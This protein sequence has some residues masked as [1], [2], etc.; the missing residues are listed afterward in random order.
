MQHSFLIACALATSLTYGQDSAPL[1]EAEQH[2]MQSITERSVLGTVSFLSSDEMAGRDTPS[3]ELRIASAY[4]AARLRGA[5]LEGLGP[6]GS[7]Y[8]THTIQT[9]QPPR[10]PARLTAEDGTVSNLLVV[11]GSDEQ[12]EISGKVLTAKEAQAADDPV[13]AIMPEIRIPP[14]AAGNPAYL[15]A[16]AARDVRSLAETGVRVVLVE[17]SDDSALPEMAERLLDR[18]LMPRRGM[19]PACSVVLVPES[20]ELA[21]QSVKLSVD[22]QRTLDEPVHNVLGILRGSDPQLSQEA[23]IVSA[24]LDHIGVSAAGSDRINNGADDNATGV[25][26]VVSMAD[27]FAA[28]KTRPAR[29][30]I[31]CTFWGEEKGLVGSSRFV[32]KPLWPLE[33]ITANINIEMV[34]R[35]EKGAQGK[36]WMTGWVHSNLGSVMNSGS[37]RAGVE[38]FHREDVSEMLYKRSDNYPFVNAGVI[39]HS[40]SAGSLHGDYHQPG[41]EWQKLDIPHMTK[42]IQGLFAGTLHVAQGAKVEKRK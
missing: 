16:M 41:D 9:T 15:L 3:K 29:S 39:A 37:M 40:F 22:A 2:A 18:A 33:K 13:I 34:G 11:T 31:F 1:T 27:A 26:A 4:V 10:N 5:G 21:G 36:A 6:E 25:T 8:Q 32:E 12:L 19:K 42:V 35:P 23:I 7:F 24:H 28:L 17:Y 14:Q 30:V 38:I 20:A